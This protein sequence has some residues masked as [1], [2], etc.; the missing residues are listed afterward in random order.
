MAQGDYV[1]LPKS[2][3]GCADAQKRRSSVRD[4]PPAAMQLHRGVRPSTLRLCFLMVFYLLFL[5]VGAAIFS[6]IEA[7]DEAGRIRAL[8]DH[9]ARFLLE[10]VCVRGGSLPSQ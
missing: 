4:R 7:P 3:G 6:A 2:G 9:R 5:V 10:N 1:S 8:R